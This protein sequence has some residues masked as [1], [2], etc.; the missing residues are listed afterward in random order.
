MGKRLRIT[1]W[2]D[3][4]TRGKLQPL[5]DCAFKMTANQIWHNEVGKEIEENIFEEEVLE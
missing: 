2:V 5:E 3:D 1:D 4:Y